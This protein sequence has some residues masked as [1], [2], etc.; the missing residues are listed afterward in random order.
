MKIRDLKKH[1]IIKIAKTSW[2]CILSLKKQEEIWVELIL[3]RTN[4]EQT[5]LNRSQ[6]QKQQQQQCT[7]NLLTESSKTNY[8]MMIGQ[9]K[10][11]Q[12]INDCVTVTTDGSKRTNNIMSL[13]IANNITA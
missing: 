7:N 9:L 5:P 4:L 3:Q 11:W 1:K 8:E 6:Q 13:H 2:T 12:T 10:I